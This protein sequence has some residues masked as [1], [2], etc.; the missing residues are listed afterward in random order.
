MASLQKDK[1]P[2]QESFEFAT[3]KSR[4]GIDKASGRAMLVKPRNRPLAT[5][6]LRVSNQVD[7]MVEIPLYRAIYTMTP[8]I[9]PYGNENKLVATYRYSP[10]ASSDYR[11]NG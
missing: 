4:A 5:I 6:T 7:F 8:L 1:S 2:T 11:F 3:T 9:T 10:D